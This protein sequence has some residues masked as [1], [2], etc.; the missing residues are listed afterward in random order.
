MP[1]SGGIVA[2]RPNNSAEKTTI[3]ASPFI[4]ART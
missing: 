3:L 2:S 1:T 4:I